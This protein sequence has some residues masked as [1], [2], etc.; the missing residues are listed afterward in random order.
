MLVIQPTVPLSARS[1]LSS[2]HVYPVADTMRNSTS[3][4]SLPLVSSGHE[5]AAQAMTTK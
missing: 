3:G 4:K 5:A 1:Q 2:W